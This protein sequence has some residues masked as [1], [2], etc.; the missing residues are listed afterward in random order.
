MTKSEQKKHHE[1]EH[2]E[3]EN[4]NETDSEDLSDSETDDEMDKIKEMLLNDTDFM[5]KIMECMKTSEPTEKSE[6]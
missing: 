2:E 4:E 1:E 3:E 5:N 6:K